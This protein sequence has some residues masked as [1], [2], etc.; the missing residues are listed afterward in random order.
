MGNG[1]LDGVAVDIPGN[2]GIRDRVNH[3]EET[4]IRSEYL[5]ATLQVGSFYTVPHGDGTRIFQIVDK[6]SKSIKLVNAEEVREKAVP[7]MLLD[8]EV[9]GH[10]DMQVSDG[11]ADSAI[12]KQHWIMSWMQIQ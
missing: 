8:M 5:A 1:L 6:L 4:L 9:W 12:D 3:T 10:V 11:F 7:P 2:A